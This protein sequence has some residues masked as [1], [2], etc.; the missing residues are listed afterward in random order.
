MKKAGYRVL[1][2]GDGDEGFRLG[3]EH[4]GEIGLL[5]TD[6]VMPKMS[7]PRVAER[8]RTSCPDAKTLYM[9]GYPDKCEGGEALR[10]QHNFIQKPF[11]PRDLLSRMREVLDG[12]PLLG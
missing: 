7:G 10:S 9:S 3:I 2:A 8:L 12:R 4:A 11:T 1:V 6:V 5:V